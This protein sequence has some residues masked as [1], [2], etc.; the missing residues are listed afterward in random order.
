MRFLALGLGICAAP[1][2]AQRLGYADMLDPSPRLSYVAVEIVVEQAPA[3]VSV[4]EAYFDRMEWRAQAGENG[5]SWDVAAMVGGPVNRLWLSSAGDALA[6]GGLDYVE[7]Q[8][9]YSRAISESGLELQAGL[10][11]DFV[12][13]PR[14]TYAVLGVQG[15]VSEPL[16]VGAFGFLSR[17]GEFTARLFA[18]YD[19]GLVPDRLILQP[20]FETEIAA[21]DVAELGIGRGPVYVEAGLRLRY[22]V[23]DAF[24][25]YLGL[26]WERLLGRT[27]RM[28]RE[29]GDQVG[30]LSLVAG[31]R[32]YF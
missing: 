8:V 22:R 17:Q 1:A 27:A 4:R 6:A 10:R 5:Y 12:P 13:R 3:E 7:V 18:L 19:I 25:P 20:A 23:R 2:S 14:R 15:D 24:A 31:L 16:Y 29:G 9:L 32:S 28:A 11:R 30:T 26:N 21:T